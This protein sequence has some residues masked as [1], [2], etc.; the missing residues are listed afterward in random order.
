MPYG[1][2][3]SHRACLVQITSPVW[4][5]SYCIGAGVLPYVWDGSGCKGYP[6]AKLTF[7]GRIRRYNRKFF[8]QEEHQKVFLVALEK[9]TRPLYAKHPMAK[10]SW[11][12]TEDTDTAEWYTRCVDVLNN[13]EKVSQGK[14]MAEVVQNKV[15]QFLNGRNGELK[16]RFEREL[17]AGQFSGFHA[18]CLTDTWIGN[19]RWAFIDLTAGP[20]SWGPAVG[21]EGVRTELSLPNVEKTIGAVA[22]TKAVVTCFR[23]S[24]RLRR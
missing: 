16:L 18:E 4:L 3:S 22:G 1:S 8:T 20:F 2:S 9:M 10:F 21:G 15:M 11:T 5:T 17:K 7:L 19:H 6:K 24:L 14:D 12:V 13:V 23:S